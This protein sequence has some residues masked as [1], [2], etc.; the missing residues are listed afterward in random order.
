MTSPRQKKMVN[1][2]CSLTAAYVLSRFP[3]T[4][5]NEREQQKLTIQLAR[6]H[7]YNRP[8]TTVCA[9]DAYKRAKRRGTGRP[10]GRP[11]ELR[12]CRTISC[13]RGLNERGQL[14]YLHTKDDEG[15]FRKIFSFF[16]IS[17]NKIIFNLMREAV[18]GTVVVCA[19]IMCLVGHY[20]GSFTFC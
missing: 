12:N 10:L 16:I 17:K 6:Q 14:L 4:Q 9:S 19:A 7:W 3:C 2:R 15:F 11:K 13:L 20:F 8:V 1:F 5:E 18:Q